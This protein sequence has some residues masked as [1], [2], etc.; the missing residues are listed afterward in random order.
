MSWQL[1]QAKLSDAASG[2]AAPPSQAAES[3]R[4]ALERLEGVGRLKPDFADEVIAQ[5]QTEMPD[6][7]GLALEI[8]KRTMR[9]NALFDTATGDALAKLGLTRAEYGVLATLRRLGAPYRQ[10]PT[11]LASGLFLTTGG[12]SNLLRRLVET[13]LVTRVADARDG[14]SSWVQL[15]SRG[16]EVAERAVRDSVAAHEALL[17]SLPAR[18]A[19]TLTNTLRETLVALGDQPSEGY[20]RRADQEAPAAAA[21]GAR[22]RTAG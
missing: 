2:V 13:G 18:T 16:V 8:A 6:I 15:T 19:K 22:R 12:M 20:E 14:R 3:N 9:L 10:R 4:L 5:W 7:A 21:R 11:E 1:A 17:A